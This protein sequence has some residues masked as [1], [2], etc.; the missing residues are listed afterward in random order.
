MLDLEGARESPKWLRL[1]V[2][3]CSPSEIWRSDTLPEN[4]LKIIVTKWL[5]ELKPFACL[6]VPCFLTNRWMISRGISR[7]TCA[8]SVIF[9]IEKGGL[10]QLSI[11]VFFFPI[12]NLPF[13]LYP[14]KRLGHYCNIPSFPT[15]KVV[16]AVDACIDFEWGRTLWPQRRVVP[17]TI[18]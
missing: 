15:S 9:A 12:T 5:H 18:V 11:A 6:S 13:S 10:W 3:D 17:K 16:P 4:W 1:P 8:N 2:A 14:A 7:I